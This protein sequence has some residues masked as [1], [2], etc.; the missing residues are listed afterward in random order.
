MVLLETPKPPSAMRLM[1]SHFDPSAVLLVP[2]LVLV[3]G[4]LLQKGV[5]DLPIDMLLLEDVLICEVNQR[6]EVLKA[7]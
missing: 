1:E 7:G 5:A 6:V 2:C 3:S 4:A